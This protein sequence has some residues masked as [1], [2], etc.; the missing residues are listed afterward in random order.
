[1]RDGTD[2]LAGL[3]QTIASQVLAEE[4]A[5]EV[6]KLADV[7]TVVEL[8]RIAWTRPREAVTEAELAAVYLSADLE[9]E[10]DG[11]AA[12]VAERRAVDATP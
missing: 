3:R 4:K 5:S 12:R 7:V 6:M 10:G 9:T 2:S 11:N 8:G 1:M